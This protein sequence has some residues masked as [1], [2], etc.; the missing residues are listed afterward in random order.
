MPVK[1]PIPKSQRE[2]SNNLRESYT[3]DGISTFDGKVNRG[4][5]RSV[6]TDNVKKFSIGLRDI[7]ETIVYYFNNVIRPSVIQNSTRKNV[8]I[9]Y[10]SPERW[11]AVQK[12]GF[13]RDK[14]GKIQAPLIMYKRDSIEKNRDLGNKMDA[15]NPINYGIF[16][17]KF[18][19]KNVYDRFNIVNNREPVD[20]YYG[21]IIPDYV[22]I[23]YSCIVFTDY[24]EQ[25]NKIVESINFASDAY[26]G[27]P[28]KFS[29]RAMID[30]YTTMTE[31][32]QGQDRKVKTEFSIN[33]LGHIV[34]DAINTQLNG[35][36]KFYSTSRVNFK[37]E[38][39][40]DMATLNKRAETQER[41][42]G[43][44]FFDTSLTGAQQ[45]AD[46]GMTAE[47]IAYV[48]L[49]NIVLADSQ[50]GTVATYTGRRFATPP[51]GFTL[52]QY[53]FQVYVNGVILAYDDRTVAEAGSNIEVTIT[54]LG[55]DLD[56]DDKV[57]LVGKFI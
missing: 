51:S 13:Y 27:N 41:E 10:G 43:F 16:K 34:P 46:V 32:N 38:T 14:N 56:D 11:A 31:L 35:Q 36:N 1:K 45:S 28:E 53:D 2:L 29:F 20:E 52:N 48:Q 40:T 19:N 18:S 39:E 8:P 24:I 3:V 15:N 49:N 54:G 37:F 4:E 42:V 7:D 47:Q 17:K 44:R 30:N 25:M 22:N 21:V 55:Y 33:M 9:I 57:L 6:K 5:Q 50:T 23:T 26:W 12:D